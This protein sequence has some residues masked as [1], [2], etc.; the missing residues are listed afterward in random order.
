MARG[1][2]A[3]I[4]LAAAGTNRTAATLIDSGHGFTPGS[5]SY[6]RDPDVRPSGRFARR[7]RGN[8]SNA[9]YSF[10]IDA[11]SVTVPLLA[12][13][14]GRR[15]TVWFMPDGESAGAEQLTI[16]GYA[17]I[18]ADW[19]FAAKARFSVSIA[20]DSEVSTTAAVVGTASPVRTVVYAGRQVALSVSTQTGELLEF[21]GG[22][23]RD[24]SGGITFTPVT[25]YLEEVF[26]GQGY[27]GRVPTTEDGA[28]TI[29][30]VHRRAS[31][32]TLQEAAAAIARAE[33]C[34]AAIETPYGWYAGGLMVPEMDVETPWDGLAS[35][36]GD[37][38]WSWDQDRGIRSGPW[39]F[40]PS[41]TKTF[42][43]STD[44]ALAPPSGFTG[45]VYAVV[46]AA[47]ATEAATATAA[48][49]TGTKK[50]KP[51]PLR[52]GIY[53][54]ADAPPAITRLIITATPAASV[55]ITLIYGTRIQGEDA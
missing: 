8:V 34:I 31:A 50:T 35:F 24:V 37:L 18:S 41:E 7:E 28:I 14:H 46:T 17:A 29:A 6:G 26:G 20:A 44:V 27:M 25:N 10:E 42:T 16:T 55:T 23:T 30:T 47:G 48:Q 22:A 4:R 40:G 32:I 52:L 49:A 12:G 1:S 19:Q 54:M 53:R 2:K 15:F 33:G 36:S 21:T 39:A 13:K 11:D 51:I 9:S 45:D 5:F 43:A 38:P 3:Q